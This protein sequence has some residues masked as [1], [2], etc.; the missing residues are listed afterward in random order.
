MSHRIFNHNA[1]TALDQLELEIANELDAKITVVY[2]DKG[3]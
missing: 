3:C 1:R 2:K